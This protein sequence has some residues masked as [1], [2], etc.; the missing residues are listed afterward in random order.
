MRRCVP[1]L[2]DASDVLD[3]AREMGWLVGTIDEVHLHLHEFSTAGVD[4]VIFG[5]Y[6]LRDLS[7]LELLVDLA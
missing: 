6:N 5:H 1:P 4:R 7:I 2:A 3:T